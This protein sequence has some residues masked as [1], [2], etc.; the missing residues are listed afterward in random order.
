M[1]REELFLTA[2]FWARKTALRLFLRI[3]AVLNS[4][5]VCYLLWSDPNFLLIIF[6][7]IILEYLNFKV[8]K[9]K[10]IDTT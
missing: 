5:I 10:T 1:I 6:D 4:L 7:S 2:D 3:F 9:E 8:I